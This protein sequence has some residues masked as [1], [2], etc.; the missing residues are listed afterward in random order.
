MSG[1][2]SVDERQR[3]LG[4]NEALFRAVNE[5]IDD[6]NETFRTKGEELETVCECGDASCVERIAVPKDEYERIRRDPTLFLLVPGHDDASA[7]AVVDE[8]QRTY[9]VVRKHP[10]GPADLAARTQ[11]D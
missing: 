1:E 3:R 6:L 9:I 5:R 2:E 7:E 11:R 4:L 8:D 10:G